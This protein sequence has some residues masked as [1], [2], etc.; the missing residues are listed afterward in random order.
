MAGSF[1]EAVRSGR[2][3][4]GAFVKTAS[5]QTLELV[6][7]A[8]QDFA[9]VDAEHA[10]F[11]LATLDRLAAVAQGKLLPTLVRP[12][13]LDPAFI[14][15]VLD[16]GF[17]GVLAPHAASAEAAQAVVQACRYEGGRR[18]FSPSTRAGGYGAPDPAAYRRAADA[19]TCVWCQIED[20]KALPQLDAIAGLEEV[21]CL[22][23]GRADLAFS[24]GVDSPADPKVVEAVRATCEAG[25]RHGRTVG[26]Y[27]GSADE[28][29]DLAALGV[30]VFV[31]GSD[32]SWV[33]AQGRANRRAFDEGLGV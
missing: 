9:V 20:A 1:R 15:Q 23:L 18:G 28:I 19:Q 27:V 31:C 3:L 8:G 13:T 5:H 29:P 4:L 24:L 2:P 10:P 11:D 25:A 6:G 17:S 32:Q 21:D 16:M 30:S 22:F 26:I 12:A 7:R 14:G 33:L